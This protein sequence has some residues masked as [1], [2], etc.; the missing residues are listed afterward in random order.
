[1]ATITV[2]EEQLGRVLT[3]VETLIRDVGSLLDSD[4]VVKKRLAQIRANP[5]IGKSEEELDEYLQKR[6]VQID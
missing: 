3:D 1:M 6:G 2:S 4:D 5:S